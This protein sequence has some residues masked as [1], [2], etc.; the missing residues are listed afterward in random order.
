[1]KIILFPRKLLAAPVGIW[2][3]NTILH[4]AEAG[5]VLESRYGEDFVARTIDITCEFD[6]INVAL[7]IL[8]IT[9][10]KTYIGPI[11]EVKTGGNNG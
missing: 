4:P 10:N 2:L 1:M 8:L 6:E 3:N 11:S 7:I 9:P 5:V